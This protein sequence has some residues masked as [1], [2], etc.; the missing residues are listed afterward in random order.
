MTI[1]NVFLRDWSLGADENPLELVFRVRAESSESVLDRL[2]GIGRLKPELCWHVTAAEEVPT[3]SLE[4][5]SFIAADRI[6]SRGL[7]PKARAR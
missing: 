7:A 4:V 5:V 2:P 3:L 6:R 1:F